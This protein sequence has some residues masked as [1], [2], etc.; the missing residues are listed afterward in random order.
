MKKLKLSKVIASSLIVASVLALNSIG[1]KSTG[2]SIE[3]LIN[4][5][6]NE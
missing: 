2:S 6:E 1:A 3:E 5:L 4:K